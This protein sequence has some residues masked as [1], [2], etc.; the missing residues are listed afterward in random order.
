MPISGPPRYIANHSITNAATSC[1]LT[2]ISATLAYC[3]CSDIFSSLNIYQKLLLAA[4]DCVSG[5]IFSPGNNLH[6]R[7]MLPPDEE[8]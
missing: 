8:L 1:S 2:P 5:Y 7:L 4:R 3:L 6:V